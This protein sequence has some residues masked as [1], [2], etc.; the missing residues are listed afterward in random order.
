[1]VIVLRYKQLC[2]SQI[3]GVCCAYRSSMSLVPLGLMLQ[4][5]R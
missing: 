5:G 2:I 4:C 1:M 3:I